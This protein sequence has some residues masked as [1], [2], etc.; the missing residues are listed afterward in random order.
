MIALL[1]TLLLKALMCAQNTKTKHMIHVCVSDFKAQFICFLSPRFFQS[2]NAL[3]R[4]FSV[5]VSPDPL[6]GSGRGP[7]PLMIVLTC[8]RR[9]ICVTLLSSVS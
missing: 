8:S 1:C 2:V 4:S 3:W 7:R 9:Y 5:I 6:W